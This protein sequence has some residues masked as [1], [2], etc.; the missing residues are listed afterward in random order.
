MSKDIAIYKNEKSKK[1]K[2]RKREKKRK[3]E[4]EKKYIQMDF[5]KNYSDL[6][7]NLS[8]VPAL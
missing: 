1:K 3:K 5:S 2:K 6:Q 8:V 7:P 4:R